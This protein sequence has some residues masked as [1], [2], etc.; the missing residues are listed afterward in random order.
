LKDKEERSVT[1][2]GL[3]ALF[4]SNSISAIGDKIYFTAGPNGEN[5]GLFGY[6]LNK[7]GEKEHDNTK[8][9]D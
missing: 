4:T 1:I 5:N 3:W 2:D 7:E 8:S 6:L 9:D